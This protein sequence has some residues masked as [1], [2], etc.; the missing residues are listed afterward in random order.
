MRLKPN[1]IIIGELRGDDALA[2]LKAW[3]TGHPGSFTTIHAG[4]AAEVLLRLDGLVQEAGV[5]P[6]PRLIC[7]TISSARGHRANAVRPAGGRDRN[8][9]RL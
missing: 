4:S 5:P 6:Q 8:H 1:R 7:E 2:L 9:Q 3:V